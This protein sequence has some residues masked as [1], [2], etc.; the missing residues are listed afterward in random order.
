MS[1]AIVIGSSPLSLIDAIDLARTGWDVEVHEGRDRLGGAWAV[2]E[3]AGR[4]NVELACHLIERE[5]SAY[6]QL[7]ELGVSLAPMDP[8][9]EV[10]PRPGVRI[11][12]ASPW[13]ATA[14]LA[15]YPIARTRS[16]VRGESD[17]AS[18]RKR[19][20][21]HVKE[22][23]DSLRDRSPVMG[24]EGGAGALVSTLARRARAE[25]VVITVDSRVEMVEVDDAGAVSVMLDRP[26][27]P[28]LLV[29]PAA[30][31][32]DRVRIGG[33]PLEGDMRTR[34][35]AHWLLSFDRGSVT[36]HSYVRYAGDPVLQRSAD[37]TTS[38]EPAS[39]RAAEQ[40]LLASVRCDDRGA[41]T[42]PLD[43]VLD[44]LR[45]HGILAGGATPRAME[46][47]R[48]QG[49]DASQVLLRGLVT[50]P[51]LRVL[52]SFGDLARTLVARVPVPAPA[53]VGASL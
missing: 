37:V 6:R 41:P 2:T 10:R 15:W 40:I 21:L 25:G 43:A 33:G 47:H 1:R 26:E 36:P 30:L 50:N 31:Q 49:R 32:P 16:F 27:S 8:Q 9:P 23:R 35:Y 42:A 24:V 34:S 19:R 11:G 7:L 17:P 18:W 5:D 12:Y 20:R 14:Q 28:D 29:V 53:K 38:A 46:C 3:F 52:D 51:R 48:Y 4:S 39:L 45:A 13:A 44:R 22:L